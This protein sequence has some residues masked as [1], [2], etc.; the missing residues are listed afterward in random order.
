MSTKAIINKDH[1]DPLHHPASH[2]SLISTLMADLTSIYIVSKKGDHRA[3]ALST[4]GKGMVGTG[5]YKVFRF[6]RDDRLGWTAAAPT[7]VKAGLVRC[8]A[9][10]KQHH[11]LGGLLD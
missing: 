1:I 9:S 6:P 5:P 10:F 7:G 8:R 11:A 3:S 2:Q 4:G